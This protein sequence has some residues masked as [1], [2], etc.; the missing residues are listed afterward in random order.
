MSNIAHF[1]NT[2]LPKT[3]GT[4]KVDEWLSLTF[5]GYVGSVSSVVNVDCFEAKAFVKD[6]VSHEFTRAIE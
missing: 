5:G 2:V 6:L 3:N 1:K 4:P